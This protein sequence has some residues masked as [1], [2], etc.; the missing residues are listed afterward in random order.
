ML[1]LNVKALENKQEWEKAGVKL[2]KFDLAKVTEKT[3]KNPTWIHFGAGNIFRGFVAE[4]HQELLNN[5]DVD[6]G[7]IATDT[8]DFEIIEKVYHPHDNLGLLVLMH[9]DGTLEKEIIASIVESVPA[10]SACDK[11]WSRMKEIFRAPSLQMASFTITE[12][13]YSLT[14]IKGE[15]L[16]VVVSDM[17]EGP[18]APKHAMAAVAALAYERFNA[19]ELPI[20]FVSMDNCSH[21]GEK[22]QNSVLAVAEA[23]VKNGFVP[24]AFLDYLN[25]TKKVTFPWSMIDKITPRPSDFVREHL[26]SNGVSGM[27]P[28]ITNRNTYI[29]PFIN[30][31][32]PRYLIVEDSFPNGHPP[33]DKTSGMFFTTRE[34]VE[35]TER[36]KVTTCLNPLHT[37]LAVY[38]CMLGFT[39]IADEM[40]DPCLSTFVK[41]MGYDESMPVVVNPGIVDP[42]QFIDEVTTMRLPNP[43]I[44]DTPQRIACDTSQKLA[45]R[46]GETIKSY[47]AHKDLD[48]NDL[49]LIPLVL[50]GWCRYVLGVDDNLEKFDLSPDPMLETMQAALAG[51]DPATGAYQ[52]QLKEVLKNK[53]LFGVD[54]YEV[55]LGDK[56]EGMFKELIAGKGAVRKT[57]E[58][59]TK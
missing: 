31:E 55:G 39:S 59:Y 26:E 29:A 56:V 10:N 57:I 40:K 44:P 47:V 22:L 58:K 5:G 32:V 34:T 33:L 23:W 16:P 52:G 41:K 17:A 19:G 43:F 15:L 50:A 14:N 11:C 18:A 8:F 1:E 28:V 4:L 3:T 27:E 36:M 42:K 25:D 2:P 53:V 13:G 49:T 21:N 9:P 48:V 54:L 24:K 46:F 20:A 7:I 30:A 12:K 6:T 45:I 37:A 38:G 51:I 35:N